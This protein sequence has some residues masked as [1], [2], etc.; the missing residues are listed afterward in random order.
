MSQ[1]HLRQL[2]SRKKTKIGERAKDINKRGGIVPMKPQRILYRVVLG[3]ILLGTFISAESLPDLPSI[4]SEET[5]EVNLGWLMSEANNLIISRGG[6]SEHITYS[7]VDILEFMNND[8]NT[9]ISI[10]GRS[11]DEVSLVN[12][13]KSNFIKFITTYSISLPKESFYTNLK[14]NQIPFRFINFRDNT[15]VLVTRLFYGVTFNTLQLNN[16]ERMLC[17][18]SGKSLNVISCLYDSF[19]NTNSQ[20]YGVI[21]TYGY[22]DFLSKNPSNDESVCLIVPRATMKKYNLL[23][24][25]DTQLLAESDIYGNGNDTATSFESSSKQFRKISL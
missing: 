10:S 11:S 24:I 25:T 22:K 3:I 17:V 20:Y 1:S 12:L 2:G 21:I 8:M 15:C 16:K 18:L 6:Q 7:W 23:E 14:K 13:Y 4:L 19:V 5:S 9:L